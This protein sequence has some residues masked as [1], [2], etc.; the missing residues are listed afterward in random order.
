MPSG[1]TRAWPSIEDATV[2]TGP[3][4][5]IIKHVRTCNRRT[6]ADTSRESKRILHEKGTPVK[7]QACQNGTGEQAVQ[8]AE[9]A[10]PV[11]T[12]DTR[13]EPGG[14]TTAAR[15]GVAPRRV[16]GAPARAHIRVTNVEE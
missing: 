13:E 16:R 5:A 3:S 8:A 2:F 12:R 9:H 6:P 11:D 14:A 1:F 10:G 15:T 4:D 7:A